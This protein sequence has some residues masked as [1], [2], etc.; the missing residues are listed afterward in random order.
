M[1]AK[2]TIILCVCVCAYVYVCMCL[3]VCACVCA[4][5]HACVYMYV[6][7]RLFVNVLSH[8]HLITT[9]SFARA[10]FNTFQVKVSLSQY[11][12]TLQNLLPDWNMCVTYSSRC[13]SCW[14]RNSLWLLRVLASRLL[15]SISVTTSP[16][17]WNKNLQPT[18]TSDSQKCY[19]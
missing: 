17:D 14:Q 2:C 15:N 9:G 4:C 13:D 10:A 11:E 18:H 6:C 8:H 16:M 12:K 5:M 1:S 3:C 7:A 19:N